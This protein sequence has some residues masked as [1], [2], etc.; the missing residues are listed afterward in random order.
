MNSLSSI[1]TKL[2]SQL[3]SP[4]E[5]DLA[6]GV[7]IGILGGVTV[8]CLINV[9]E[10][11]RVQMQTGMPFSDAMRITQKA[12]FKGL[13]VAIINSV[14]KNTFLFGSIPFF[15]SF[16]DQITTH[17]IQSQAAAS[18]LAGLAT[19][20]TLAPFSVI[21]KRVY[22]QHENTPRIVFLFLLTPEKWPLLF[23]GASAKALS[24][25]IYWPIFFTVSDLCYSVPQNFFQ[26]RSKSWQILNQFLAGSIAACIASCIIHPLELIASQQAV[27]NH[28]PSIWMI[29]KNIKHKEGWRGFTKGIAMNIPSRTIA[30]ATT[31]I[32][33]EGVNLAFQRLE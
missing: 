12:P 22:T 3:S 9:F 13:S 18:A 23:A 2:N 7:T 28:K 26:P 10:Q 27:S 14:F 25:P 30:G 24:Y 17:P 20:Y 5:K 8:P 6:R 29:V 33:I 31:K 32:V 16:T 1:Y 4:K 19:A 15:L 11:V 21:K